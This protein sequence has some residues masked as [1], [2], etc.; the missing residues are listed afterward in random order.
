M[1]GRH[2]VLG[3]QAAPGGHHVEA[4]RAVALHVQVRLRVPVLHH[5]D[6]PRPAVRQVVAGHAL[7]ALGTGGTGVGGRPPLPQPPSPSSLVTLTSGSEM[8]VKVFFSGYRLGT[9]YS[10]RE[11]LVSV[12]VIYV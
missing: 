4:V 9:S 2:A 11:S 5:H 7:A 3:A 12:R 10:L 8:K 6:E 1:Q